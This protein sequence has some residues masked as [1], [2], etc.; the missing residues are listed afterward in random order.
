MT[1]SHARRS[2]RHIVVMSFRTLAACSTV[3]LLL[4]RASSARAQISGGPSAENSAPAVLRAGVRFFV[5]SDAAR[6]QREIDS[7]GAPLLRQPIA[8]DLRGL[9]KTQA[10]AEIGRAAGVSLA[11]ASAVITNNE[12]L[13]F[14]RPASI[15]AALEA[16]L[17]RLPV[18]VVVG[19]ND[20]L[21]LLARTAVPARLDGLVVDSLSR[22]PVRLAA[23]R[24]DGHPETVLTDD[25]G[26]FHVAAVAG[27]I[28]LTV[29]RIGYR[30]VHIRLVAPASGASANVSLAPSAVALSPVLVDGAPT[31]R[32]SAA[33]AAGQRIMA[34]VLERRRA[35]R[36]RL[37]NYRF[38]AHVLFAERDTTHPADSLASVAG[39][40]GSVIQGY[41]ERR[42]EQQTIVARR[43][44]K[45]PSSGGV[46]TWSISV[47]NVLTAQD[48]DDSRWSLNG[49][50]PSALPSPL[51]EDALA[52]YTFSVLDTL[53]EHGVRVIRLSIQPRHPTRGAF[54]GVLDVS[55]SSYQL[56]ELDAGLSRAT[57]DDLS[58]ENLRVRTRFAEV[59]PGIVLPVRL[60][61]E[62]HGS[63]NFIGTAA[64]NVA[65]TVAMS[66][67][68]INEGT[69]PSGVVEYPIVIADS[70]DHA[71]PATFAAA[72]PI[73]LTPAEARVWQIVDSTKA[74][75]PAP[76][77]PGTFNVRVQHVSLNDLADIQ[78]NRVNGWS[79]GVGGTW[80]QSLADSTMTPTA[81][82]I[83][84]FGSRRLGYR[85]GDEVLLSPANRLSVSAQYHSESVTLPE[86]ASPNYNPS[87]AALLVGAGADRLE[88]Y[89]ERGLNTSIST[90]LVGLTQLTVDY[91][92]ERQ[93]SLAVRAGYARSRGGLFGLIPPPNTPI[94]DGQLHAVRAT[95]AYDSRA[96]VL[97]P[98]GTERTEDV[99]SFAVHDGDDYTTV[100]LEAESSPRARLGGDFDYRRYVVRI[101][102]HD[103]D[104]LLGTTDIVAIAGTS[105]GFLPAQ[106]LFLINGGA[107]VPA[108]DEPFSTVA[109]SVF[110]GT[111]AAAVT[112]RHTLP[113]DLLRQSGIPVIRS[114]PLVFTVGA[115]VFWSSF[116]DKVNASS[117]PAVNG[118]LLGAGSGQRP[119]FVRA[120][121]TPYGEVGVTVAYQPIKVI[122]IGIA[123]RV[124]RQLSHY[125]STQTRVTIGEW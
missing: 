1:S 27:A 43:E 74:V 39:L 101:Q 36:Q 67:Y 100:S 115:S 88:Y 86:F 96:L 81:K 97:E 10:L 105:T 104:W 23:V 56:V 75:A 2:P 32:D 122:P 63:F 116:D 113:D 57:Y 110:G 120:A 92:D 51:A 118:R 42:H 94:E 109:D 29:R 47:N 22:E 41:W 112:L 55:D 66:D 19:P 6:P 52:H 12:T 123:V 84:E 35:E 25:A 3:A 30:P 17:D 50:L 21:I 108:T 79:L 99:G 13:N 95:I 45:N 124:G 119:V 72:P 82:L 125:A 69:R 33:R 59:D 70:A 93:S 76:T 11:Y 121:G 15:G 24:L 117:I 40:H 4:M 54:D 65:Y 73:P 44:W 62:A 64:L 53:V 9:T 20:A 60:E 48:F 71:K 61:A 68:R 98:H 38:Q 58:I 111:R 106:R 28:D 107:A 16:V 49:V 8:V 46:M 87:L 31:A 102:R 90:R 80:K 37:R 78:F 34:A 7:G 5:S 26:R 114:L 14:A 18:D 91:V 85:L 77:P 103:E 83:Y 89:R